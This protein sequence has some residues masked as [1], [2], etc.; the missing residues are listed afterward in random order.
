MVGIL[1]VLHRPLPKAWL[2]VCGAVVSNLL[3][4]ILVEVSD[5]EHALN[6]D[7]GT[8]TLPP[9]LLPGPVSSFLCHIF[10]LYLASHGLKWNGPAGHRLKHLKPWPKINIFS[11]KLIKS[12]IIYYIY[13]YWEGVQNYGAQRTTCRSWFPIPGGFWGQTQVLGPG[14][15]SLAP[16]LVFTGYFA[17][18]MEWCLVQPR[19]PEWNLSSI[20]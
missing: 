18:A 17:T 9:S 15:I 16:K 7:T 20:S 8:L 14:G 11:F 2:S 13:L 1:N 10:P 5:C 3:G 19:R 12:F 6:R 4:W